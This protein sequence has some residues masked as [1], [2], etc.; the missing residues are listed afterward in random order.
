MKGKHDL[1]LFAVSVVGLVATIID[2]R[3]IEPHQTYYVVI[4]VSIC[5][6]WIL[7]LPGSW[8]NTAQISFFG[9]MKYVVAGIASVFMLG[10]VSSINM[11]LYDGLDTMLFLGW[12]GAV[13]A[14]SRL[15]APVVPVKWLQKLFGMTSND[16]RNDTRY[17]T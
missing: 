3:W 8:P 17:G 13:V 16:T 2:G 1:V 11:L 4:T 10:L 5:A 6:W 15:I 7:T 14:E 12:L 9:K